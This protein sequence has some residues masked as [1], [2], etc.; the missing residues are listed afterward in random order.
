MGAGSGTDVGAN[1]D[2]NAHTNAEA[3]TNDP[4]AGSE[5]DSC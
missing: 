5:R 1:A 4:G 2:T 3:D